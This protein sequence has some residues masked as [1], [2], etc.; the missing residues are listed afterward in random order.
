[1]M[2]RLGTPTAPFDSVLPRPSSR[3][4]LLRYLRTHGPTSQLELAKALQLNKG[5][6]SRT[7]KRMIDSG[8]LQRESQPSGSRGRPQMEIDFKAS[9][10]RGIGI[11]IEPQKKSKKTRVCALALNYAG[12]QVDSS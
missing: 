6:L 9:A 10:G 2:K 4:E 8:L 1:M 11:V 7:I 3:F 12:H 5:A